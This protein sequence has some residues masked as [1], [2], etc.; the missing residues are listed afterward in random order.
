MLRLPAWTVSRAPRSLQGQ[1]LLAIALALLVAQGLSAALIWREQ[2]ERRVQLTVNEAAFRLIGQPPRE[3]HA[4]DGRPHGPPR[5]MT[6]GACRV[7][8]ACASMA[9][10][11]RRRRPRP[12]RCRHRA[13]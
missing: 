6:C 4:P 8:C 3:N 2:N 5:P 13:S 12:R 9:G 7:R 11:R 1:M 10:R